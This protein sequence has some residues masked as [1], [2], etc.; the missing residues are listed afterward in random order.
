VFISLC[1]LF[2]LQC[3]RL[4]EVHGNVF[5]ERCERCNRQYFRDH[6]LQSVGRKPTGKQC[7]GSSNRPC[8]GRLRDFLLDWEDE[9]PEPEFGLAYKFAT[10]ADLSICLGTSLQIAPVCNMPLL[11]KK[12][13]GNFITVN[14]QNTKHVC[15]SCFFTVVKLVNS[16]KRRQT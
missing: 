4:A 14:L 2:E 16:R 8:R 12:K 9:L 10:A 1:I 15:S 7:E 3:F 6:P 5:V 11:V 13:G